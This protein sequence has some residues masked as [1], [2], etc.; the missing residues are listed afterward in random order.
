[1]Q[2]E[3]LREKTMNTNTN[4][5]AE[6]TIVAFKNS[7]HLSF[8]GEVDEEKSDDTTYTRKLSDCNEEELKLIR[9]YTEYVD[10]SIKVYADQKLEAKNKEL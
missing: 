5:F 6:A 10:Y 7:G 3:K 9:S 1:V 2:L 4:S 8:L